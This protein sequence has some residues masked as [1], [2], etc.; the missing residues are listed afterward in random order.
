MFDASLAM[1]DASL[2]SSNACNSSSVPDGGAGASTCESL[3]TSPIA[4]W[5]VVEPL[6][7]SGSFAAFMHLFRSGE[8]KERFKERLLKRD[9]RFLTSGVA[10]LAVY[11]VGV[12]AWVAVVPPPVG[13]ESGCVDDAWS[14]LQLCAQIVSGLVAYDFVFFWLHLGMHASPRLGQLLGHARHHEYDGTG[15]AKLESSFRTTHHGL[16]DGTLQVTYGP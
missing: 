6:I 11:W 10:S 12:A 3:L 8:V 7:A 4:T 16:I 13:V 14:L 2:T 9:Q 5:W 15:D 1:F